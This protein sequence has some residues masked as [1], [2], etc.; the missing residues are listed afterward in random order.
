MNYLIA[1]AVVPPI[2]LIFIFTCSPSFAFGTCITKP[3]T[4]AMPSPF[5]LGSCQEGLISQITTF[6]MFPATFSMVIISKILVIRSACASFEALA[7]MAFFY[8]FFLYLTL[9]SERAPLIIKTRCLLVPCAF[10]CPGGMYKGFE[11]YVFDP[12]I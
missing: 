9:V 12:L 3:S 1:S 4:F 2:R 10:F 8:V 11:N 7:V 6:E 5:G